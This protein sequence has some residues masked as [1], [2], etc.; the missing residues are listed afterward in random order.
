MNRK[1]LLA[2][3]L[4]YECNDLSYINHVIEILNASESEEI[5]NDEIGDI[6]E[7]ISK[8]LDVKFSDDSDHDA[9][10]LELEL[11]KAYKRI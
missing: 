11:S 4:S 8:A 3:I 2:R 7:R 9:W 6:W 10:A 5:S 1:A